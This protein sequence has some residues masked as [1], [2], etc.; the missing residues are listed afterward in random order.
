[1]RRL[2]AGGVPWLLMWFYCLSTAVLCSS[3]TLT[4]TILKNP[5]KIFIT[6]YLFIKINRRYWKTCGSA[7]RKLIKHVWNE[8]ET[9]T[10]C[11]CQNCYSGIPHRTLPTTNWTRSGYNKSQSGWKDDS[12]RQ[13]GPHFR[14]SRCVL[15]LIYKKSG[16]R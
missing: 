4:G 5:F 1:M 7:G 8:K 6:N 16:M 15:I 10:R 11:G 12:I 13:H 2:S 3:S 14:P 9:E